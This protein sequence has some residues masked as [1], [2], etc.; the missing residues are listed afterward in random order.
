MDEQLAELIGRWRSAEQRLYPTVVV[1]PQQYERYLRLIR[2]ITD[3]LGDRSTAEELAEAYGERMR[4]LEAAAHRLSS[5]APSVGDEDLVIGAA[6]Y[7]RYRE[8]RAEWHQAEV[9]ERIAAA[10]QD[11]QWVLLGETGTAEPV[12]VPGYRRLE[13]H[14]PDGTGLHTFVEFDPKTYA[15][16]YGVELL[17]LDPRTGEHLP[18]DARPSRQEFLDPDQW[19]WAV[20]RLRLAEKPWRAMA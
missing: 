1:D 7:A 11:P 12:P 6:F 4:F 20:A 16:L 10:G 3:D 9:M 19:E 14:V 17:R 8:L 2:A 5:V 13:M 18:D 15:P